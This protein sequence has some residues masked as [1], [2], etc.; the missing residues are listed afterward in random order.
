LIGYRPLVLPYTKSSAMPL[1][2]E[3]NRDFGMPPCIG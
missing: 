3:P 2:S 1:N